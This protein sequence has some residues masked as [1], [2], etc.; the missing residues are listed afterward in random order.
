MHVFINNMR[1]N[2]VCVCVC[3]CVCDVGWILCV[4]WRALQAHDHLVDTYNLTFILLGPV[5]DA[6]VS[7]RLDIQLMGL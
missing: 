7:L 2:S 3:V 5:V 6:Q 4:F 1:E